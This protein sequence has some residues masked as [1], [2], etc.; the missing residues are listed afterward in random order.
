M[1]T[2]VSKALKCLKHTPPD[3]PQ[4][5]PHAWN[6]RIYG[7]HTQVVTPPDNLPILPPQGMKYIQAVTGT[8]FYYARAIDP[9]ILQATNDIASMQAHSTNETMKIV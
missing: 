9:T 2:Y 3:K 4:Y 8:F 6:R 7:E 5:S 1:P